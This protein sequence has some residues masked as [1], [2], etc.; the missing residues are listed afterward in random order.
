VDDDVAGSRAQQDPHATMAEVLGSHL[1]AGDDI[2]HLAV[3]V[4]DLDEIV[5]RRQA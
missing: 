4:D 5:R 3:L 2:D 1:R